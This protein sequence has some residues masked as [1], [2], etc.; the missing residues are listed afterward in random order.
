MVFLS[1]IK[2]RIG[3]DT[4]NRGFLL[5]RAV[6]EPAGTL[7]KVEYFLNLA[8]ECLAPTEDKDYDFFV[9]QREK[10]E[11]EKFLSSAGIVKGDTLVIIHPGGNWPPKR[12]PKER[13]AELADRIASEF[14]A[15]VVITGA[16]HDAGLAGDIAGITKTGPVNAVGKTTIKLLAALMERADLVISSDSGPMHLAVA[17][18]TKVIA[19]FGP[20]SELITG[21]YGTGDF[22]VIKK[23]VSCRVPCYDVMCRD[24]RCMNMI[25]VDEVFQ[26]AKEKLTRTGVGAPLVGAL[27][28]RAGTRPAPTDV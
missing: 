17:V 24:H 19:L 13:F 25:S 1:G 10:E 15:K 3:Y 6:R 22:S 4:K 11:A 9:P 20:T 7:H 23:S 14:S 16:P 21:P 26:K 27:N 28:N 18:R 2:N 12:W 5:T 8:G